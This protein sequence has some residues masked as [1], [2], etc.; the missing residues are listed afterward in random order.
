MSEFETGDKIDGALES[1]ELALHGEIAF[2]KDYI[3][4][5]RVGGDAS[6]LQR[7]FD[8]LALAEQKL[9]LLQTI[10]VNGIEMDK[11]VH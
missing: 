11:L 2:W 10:D 3:Q 6:V 9:A 1:M 7:A 8:A 5:G 4:R